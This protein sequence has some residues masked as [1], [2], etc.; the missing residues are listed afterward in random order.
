MIPGHDVGFGFLAEVALDQ[1][2]DIRARETDLAPVMN[3]HP[4]L[5]GFGLDHNVSITVHGD[6]LIVNGPGRLAVWD[7]R[8]RNR[9]YYYLRGGD[10]LEVSTRLPRTVP[11][12]PEPLHTEIPIFE[13]ALRP[14]VGLYESS[15]GVRMTITLEDGHMMSQLP[16]EPRIRLFPETDSQFFSKVGQRQVRLTRDG[17]GQ[18]VGLTL[19]C[20]ETDLLFTRVVTIERHGRPALPAVL[21]SIAISANYSSISEQGIAQFT[22]TGSY[23][24]GSTAD[25]TN[26]A[27]WKSTAPAVATIDSQ[28][29]ASAR[30]LGQTSVTASLSGLTSNSLQLT[31]VAGN[32]VRSGASISY[33]SLLREAKNRTSWATSDNHGRS[34]AVSNQRALSLGLRAITSPSVFGGESCGTKSCT[35]AVSGLSS[36]SALSF[37]TGTSSTLPYQ[38]L[39]SGVAPG[40]YT[41]TIG[42][43]PLPG[44]PFTVLANDDSLR[45]AGSAGVVNISP[46]FTVEAALVSI[47]VSAKS[48]SLAYGSTEQFTATGTYNDGSA[49]DL[50]DQVTWVSTPPRVV[51]IS[52]SGVAKATQVGH[53]SITATLNG[54]VSDTFDVTVAKKPTSSR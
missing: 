21:S 46:S 14:Y 22:A 8:H 30:A 41:V 1:D 17:A 2:V 49:I 34:G 16:G 26:Q 4:E 5:L 48:A 52:S 40:V 7:G 51:A 36:I 24:D 27:S 42:G 6:S 38:Y 47:V 54:L 37:E 10:M 29:L 35:A 25:I 19:H 18:V 53:A 23:G 32:P 33:A 12:A 44:E 9:G 20:G 11:H 3:V 28:G 43:R 13:D 45:F 31:V 15:S 39:I 50:T